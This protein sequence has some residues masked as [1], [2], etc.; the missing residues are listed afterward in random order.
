MPARPVIQQDQSA[1]FQGVDNGQALIFIYFTVTPS[2]VYVANGDPFDFS[3][4]GDLIK[5]SRPP[6]QVTMQG[7]GGYFY[8]YV[9]AAV[10]TQIN[11]KFKVL[12]CAGAG[13]PAADIGGGAYPA[14]VLADVI[15]GVAVFPRV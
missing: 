8:V 14:G 5:S 13:A 3:V 7:V 15:Q 10:P 6:L 9:A 11:G 2:G 12:Q 1:A 4:L